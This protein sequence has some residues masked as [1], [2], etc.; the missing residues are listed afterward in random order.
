MAMGTTDHEEEVEEVEGTGITKTD[1]IMATT[2]SSPIAMADQDQPKTEIVIRI[3]VEAA[4]L[5]A[6]GLAVARLEVQIKDD[7]MR[8]S[9]HLH[10]LQ[11]ETL[12]SL[13]HRQGPSHSP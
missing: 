13:L 3:R 12:I 1:S 6:V 9:N 2:T 11:R 8:M 10:R 4:R 7:P 5:L